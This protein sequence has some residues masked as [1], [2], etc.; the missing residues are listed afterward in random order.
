MVPFVPA[1]QRPRSPRMSASESEMVLEN[2]DRAPWWGKLTHEF[3]LLLADLKDDPR[4]RER[5]KHIG[6]LLADP[7]FPKIDQIYFVPK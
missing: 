5:V 3:G 7:K 4:Y 1:L 2:M 6:E